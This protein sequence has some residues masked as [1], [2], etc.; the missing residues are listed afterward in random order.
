VEVYPHVHVAWILKVE[1]FTDFL[2]FWDFCAKPDECGVASL[3]SLTA[4]VG[5]FLPVE[6]TLQ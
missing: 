1:S 6:I 5:I 3:H 2:L 4:K